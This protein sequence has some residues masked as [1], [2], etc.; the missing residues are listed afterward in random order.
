LS[1]DDDDDAPPKLAAASTLH[2]LSMGVSPLELEP[3]RVQY[4]AAAVR[5]WS[6]ELR[7]FIMSGG[8]GGGGAASRATP[9]LLAMC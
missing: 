7:R 2:E 5:A 4:G 9:S 6:R 8:G 3:C 1:P